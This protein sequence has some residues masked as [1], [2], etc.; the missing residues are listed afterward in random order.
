MHNKALLFADLFVLFSST[1]LT[2]QELEE[3]LPRLDQGLPRLD[4]RP[5]FLPGV[6]VNFRDQLD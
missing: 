2:A 6:C 3:G 4:L 1:Q 5:I